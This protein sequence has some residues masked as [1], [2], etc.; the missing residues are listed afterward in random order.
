MYI[1]KRLRPI[2][3]AFDPRSPTLAPP[4]TPADHCL[5]VRSADTCDATTLTRGTQASGW[6]AGPWYSGSPLRVRVRLDGAPAANGTASAHRAVAGD[7]GFVLPVGCAAYRSGSHR[8]EAECL[9][10]Y[11]SGPVSKWFALK[12]SPFCT[13]N[14]AKATCP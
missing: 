13:E 12:G 9:Y 11:A 10:P 8:F 4:P 3:P 5:R 2:L 14:G 7:H 6:C 1:S